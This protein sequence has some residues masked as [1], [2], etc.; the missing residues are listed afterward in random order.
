MCNLRV[1]HFTL[2]LVGSK[3]SLPMMALPFLTAFLALLTAWRG[4][5][6]ATMGLWALTVVVML[7]LVKLHFTDALDIDL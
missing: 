7:V 6:G 2:I 1:C 4:W 3:R 5:R